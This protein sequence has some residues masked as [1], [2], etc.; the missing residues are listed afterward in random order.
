MGLLRNIRELQS[1]ARKQGSVS[2][3]Q[4][5]PKNPEEEDSLTGKVGRAV[6]NSKSTGGN[7]DIE[8]NGFSPVGL[9]KLGREHFSLLLE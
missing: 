3:P 9:L 1:R 6:T 8:Y 2:K 5:S 4:T 7:Q